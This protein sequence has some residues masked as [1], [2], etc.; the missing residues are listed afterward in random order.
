MEGLLG[1]IMGYWW[2]LG[3]VVAVLIFLMSFKN[4]IKLFGFYLIPSNAIGIVNKKFTLLGKHRSL[5]DGSL[6]A[7]NGEPGL[8]ADTLAPGLKVG[9]WPWQYKV[10]IVPFVTVQDGMLGLVESR[11]GKAIPAGKVL[12]KHVDCETFQNARKFLEG[13]GERGPQIS[14]IPPGT[15]RINT[16]LFKVTF[17]NATVIPQDKVG[18]VT[19]KE[20]TPLEKDDIAGPEIEGHNVFQD[21]SAFLTRGGRK[22]LQEQVMLAGTYFLNPNFVSVKLVDYTVVPIACVGVVISFVGN[23]GRDTSGQ[24]FEHG[25]IVS[26]GQKGVWDKP[27]DPGRYAINTDCK[28]MEIVSTAN[29]VLNWANNRSESHELDKEL[30]SITVRSSDGFKF[31]L[32]VSQIIHVPSLAAPKVI[33]RFGN[34]KNLVTQVLEPIIGNYFRNSAQKSDVISFLAERHERQN[35]AKSQIEAALK[36]Y[37]V[38]GVD[39]LIGDINPPEPLMKTLTDRKIAEQEKTT[40]VT[41]KQA[42]ETRRDLQQARAT[43]D[44][45]PAVVQAQRNV[46][47]AEFDASSKIKKAK[48]DA[49]SKTINA[50]ADAKVFIVTGEAEGKKITAVGQAEAEVIKKKTDAQGQQQYAVVEVARALAN[51]KEKWV[52]E[53]VFSGSG[54]GGGSNT[55]AEVLMGTMLK[56][57]IKTKSSAQ[58]PKAETEKPKAEMP[59]VV[60]EAPKKT[61]ES[62]DEVP[63]T[64]KGRS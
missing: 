36:Q 24:E 10:T 5:P 44:T 2:V 41:Q 33:A 25:N 45:Q 38:K 15:W 16:E 40:Y 64:P 63:K 9:Y 56:D 32:D 49:E 53:I 13:N 52:P 54:E 62:T 58:T 11:D 57:V 55:I 3:L 23:P 4:V 14:I 6:V 46:E 42:E 31:N 22:G 1:S 17:V 21:G 19:T 28:R 39:T 48:G 7:L 8:Q 26:E 27:L 34:M 18:I 35:E 20:G 12:A 51:S 60:V 29:I 61:E 50:E 59:K 30:S 43:A 37:D 47:I